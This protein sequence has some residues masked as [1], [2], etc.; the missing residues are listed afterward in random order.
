LAYFVHRAAAYV[1]DCVLLLAGLLFWQ[2]LLYVVNPSMALVRTGQQPTG[3]Q[4]HLWVFAT[5]SIPFWLY[6][7]FTQSSARQATLGMRLFKLKVINL[8][9]A[10]YRR[11]ASL[12]PQRGDV[13]SI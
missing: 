13:N 3:L 9:G 2:A 10:A 1:V 5:A 12:A 11:W 6:F 4:L 7:A 8:H